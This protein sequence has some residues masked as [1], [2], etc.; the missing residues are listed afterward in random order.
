M[1]IS[2]DG[3]VRPTSVHTRAS[4]HAY[5]TNYVMTDYAVG[6]GGSLS[7]LDLLIII[8]IEYVI[9][10]LTTYTSIAIFFF[11]II[12]YT[13]FVL[14]YRHIKFDIFYIVFLGSQGFY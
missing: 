10:F 4:V 2:S 14:S 5:K 7:S 12:A 8:L 1:F 9:E 6:L 3:D 13:N 11:I